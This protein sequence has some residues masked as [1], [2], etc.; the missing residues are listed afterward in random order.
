MSFILLPAG[1]PSSSIDKAAVTNVVQISINEEKP[2]G[3]LGSEP[4][5]VYQRCTIFNTYPRF[6]YLT[7]G[8]AGFSFSIMILN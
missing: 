5:P 4:R 3:R 6:H 1:S 8:M 7:F 2:T